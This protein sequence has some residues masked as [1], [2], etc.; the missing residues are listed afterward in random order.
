[1]KK[2]SFNFHFFLSFITFI[3]LTSSLSAQSRESWLRLERNGKGYG[4]DHIIVE[5]L[6]NG[7]VK[8]KISQMI[9]TDIAG[10]NPQDII[11]EGYY[12]VDEDMKPV[13]FDLSIRFQTKETKLRGETKDGLLLLSS[14]TN[15]E[16]IKSQEIPFEDVFFEIVLGNLIY[17]RKDEGNFILKIFNPVE[18]KINEYVVEV[19]PDAKEGIIAKARERITMI[20]HI[21]R[22]GLVKQ[23]KFVELNSRSY[24][25]TAKNA[26]NIDYLNTA[27]GL[28]LTVQADP[29]F[30][31]VW[32]I[33]KAQIS[34]KWKGIPFEEF[35][36]V[37]N[38]QRAIEKAKNGEEYE[39]VLEINKP[40]SIPEY[41]NFPVKDK[42]F[43]PFLDDTEY[44]KPNDPSI[45]KK[46]S[47]IREDDKDGLA[48]VQKILLWVY[49]NVKTEYIAETLSG[50]EVLRRKRGK[51]VEYS[52]LFASLARAGGIPT[53]VVFGEA[54]NG[55][56]WVG[57]I[58]CEVWLGEWIGVD[59]AAGIFIESPTHIKFTHSPTVMG[60]QKIRWKLV[61]NLA[62]AILTFQK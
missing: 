23:I 46:L 4:F 43:K 61:D 22:N 7:Q 3:I 50:P 56:H 38:R 49:E 54:L 2:G 15:E 40:L 45:Q 10:F 26:Q 6:E 42:E 20:F 8:Y 5:D 33:N 47:E 37:D 21:D 29:C 25:T 18:E 32:D 55:N 19:L 53:R 27:D 62:I 12:I 34:I 39:A 13:A 36:F 60:T 24:A 48:L 59:A 35:H 11:Q 17:Q 44:I 30:P 52:T 31:S 9:K 58:W 28:T 51:C 57:H 16:E 41:A 14:Q 1:M